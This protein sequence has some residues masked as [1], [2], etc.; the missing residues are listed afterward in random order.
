MAKKTIEEQVDDNSN[1][2]NVIE[3]DLETIKNNHLFHLE[4]D[5]S[6]LRQTVDKMDTRMW[7]ILILLVSS[8]MAGMFGERLITLL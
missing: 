7:A 1:M 2:L 8:I 5:V 6:R 3:R 4:Q